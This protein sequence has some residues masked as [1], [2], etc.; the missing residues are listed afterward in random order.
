MTTYHARGT[1]EGDQWLADVP[2]L[3]G[4][5]TYAA[6]LT[7]LDRHVR[8]AIVLAA[9]LPDDAMAG[10]EL[11][12]SYDIGNQL[13]EQAAAIRAERAALTEQ[14]KQLDQATRELAAKLTKDLGYSVRDVGPLLGISHQRV[15]Q[16]NSRRTSRKTSTTQRVVR[17]TTTAHRIPAKTD[18]A[19]LA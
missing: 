2:E 12:W 17:K 18:E 1:R 11:V 14:E 19:E 8:E 9:D 13:G 6:S 15:S 16:L 7:A 4:T 5:Q 10:L 3:E